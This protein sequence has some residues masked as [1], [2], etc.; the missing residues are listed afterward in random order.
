GKTPSSAGLTL[1]KFADPKAPSH[2]IQALLLPSQVITQANVEDVV[3]AGALTAP[4]ICKGI[5]ADCT[6]FGVK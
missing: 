4:Q 2:N 6:K 3:T 5:Q 1:T